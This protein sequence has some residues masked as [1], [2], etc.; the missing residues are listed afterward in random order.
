[1]S[2]T[3][4]PY[5]LSFF[6]VLDELTNHLSEPILPVKPRGSSVL[7]PANRTACGVSSP[8]TAVSLSMIAQDTASLRHG[9]SLATQELHDALFQRD[10]VHTLFFCSPGCPLSELGEALRAQFPATPLVGCTTAGEIGPLGYRTA[11]L[12]GVSFEVTDFQVAISRI[13]E[14]DDSPMSKAAFLAQSALTDL[15]ARGCLPTGSNTFGLMLI[16]GL[17]HQ[18]EVIANA[19]FGQL[20]DIQRFGGSAAD[21]TRFEHTF[22][23]HE[24]DFHERSAVFILIDTHLPFTLFKTEHFVATDDKM[25]VTQADSSR[26]LVAGINGDMEQNGIKEQVGRIYAANNVIGFSTYDDQ[27]NAMHVNQT[28]TGVA[29]GHAA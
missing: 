29:I 28:L 3:D 25:V 20:G 7:T 17:S 8:G 26:L 9:A 23:F 18:E 14:I 19:L 6:H 12:T 16:D 1:V 27:F 11:S 22:V 24:G 4:P 10:A 2:A 13:D 15:R 21:G 5:F